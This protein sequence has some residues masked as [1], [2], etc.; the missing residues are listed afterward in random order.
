MFFL[1][2]RGVHA[3]NTME[4]FLG[5]IFSIFLSWFLS[6]SLGVKHGEIPYP[7]TLA[8]NL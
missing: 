3:G 5:A 1:Q 4:F 2:K 8:M 6:T 7:R